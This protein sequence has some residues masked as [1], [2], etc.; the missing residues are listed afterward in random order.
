MPLLVGR[1]AQHQEGHKAKH[2]VYVG[3]SKQDLA[4]RL[5][6]VTNASLLGSCDLGS[7]THA[8][9]KDVHQGS[10]PE[11]QGCRTDGVERLLGQTLGSKHENFRDL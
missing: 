3:C 6:R 9:R 8:G 1:E 10:D 5:S 2:G 11:L 7:S 4:V